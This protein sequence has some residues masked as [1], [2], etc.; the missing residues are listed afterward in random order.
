[1]NDGSKTDEGKEVKGR[2]EMRPPLMER[3]ARLEQANW[4]GC[5]LI[6]LLLLISMLVIPYLQRKSMYIG[7]YQKYGVT[8]KKGYESHILRQLREKGGYR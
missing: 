3:K 2:R 1:M 5:I 4:S 8:E 6:L 7:F